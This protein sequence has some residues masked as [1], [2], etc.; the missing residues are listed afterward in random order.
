MTTYTQQGEIVNK[1]DTVIIDQY[2]RVKAAG[3]YPLEAL[4]AA[5]G[6]IMT[7]ATPELTHEILQDL[8]R[9]HPERETKSSRAQ[10][11]SFQDPHSIGN[12]AIEGIRTANGLSRIDV[13]VPD[14]GYVGGLIFDGADIIVHG[15]AS[16]FRGF[17]DGDSIQEA[18]GATFYPPMMWVKALRGEAYKNRPESARDMKIAEYLVGLGLSLGANVTKCGDIV[19]ATGFMPGKRLRGSWDDPLID[20][21]VL[22]EETEAFRLSGLCDQ[23]VL[24]PDLLLETSMFATDI[25]QSGGSLN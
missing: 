15:H 8:G 5:Q 4:E 7:V 9:S 12:R 25:I 1:L 19:G 3:E 11:R 23:A 20:G 14:Q 16:H 2:A 10:I 13:L 6:E 24:D 17:K 22:S 18:M 21:H